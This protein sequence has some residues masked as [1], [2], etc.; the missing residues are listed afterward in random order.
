MRKAVYV[1]GSGADTLRF[2][3]EVQFG[4]EDSNGLAIMNDGFADFSPGRIQAHHLPWDIDQAS[5]ANAPLVGHSLPGHKVNAAVPT[6]TDVRVVST[7]AQSK[8]Y[9]AGENILVVVTFSKPVR[10]VGEPVLTLDIRHGGAPPQDYTVRSASYLGSNT[11]NTLTFKYVVQFGDN[12]DNGFIVSE[13]DNTGLGEGTIKPTDSFLWDWD[14][15]HGFDRNT[16]PHVQRSIP[17][18]RIATGRPSISDV[19]I[20]SSPADGAAYRLGETVEFD[21]TF[22]GLVAVEGAPKL[23]LRVNNPEVD[24]RDAKYLRKA[25]YTSGS[26]TNKL[27][28]S[29]AI[30]LGDSD[31]NGLA[32]RK[33]EGG[34]IH[35][36]QTYGVSAN[37]STIESHELFGRSLPGQEVDAALPTVTRVRV[38]S[39]PAQSQGYRVGDPIFVVV[40]FDKPVRVVGEPALTLDIRH[41]GAP[42]QDFTVRSA[43]YVGSNGPETL[44]FSYIVQTGDNDNNG[45]IVS[46]SD[47]TGLGEGTIKPAESSL[48]DLDALH[49]FD[50][51]TSPHVQR[52]IPGQRIATG[53]AVITD[54]E[55]ASS[56]ADGRAY[57]R[58]ES[59]EIDVTFNG[60]VKAVG[61][62]IL[63]LLVRSAD[64]AEDL[65]GRDYL[66]DAVYASGSGTETIRFSYAVRPYDQDDDGIVIRTNGLSSESG[67]LQSAHLPWDVDRD[68]LNRH[69]NVGSPRQ[70][71]AVAGRP[72]V[73][74]VDVTSSPAE[75]KVYRSGEAIEIEL[76]FDDRVRVEDTPSLIIRLDGVEQLAEY[77]SGNGSERLRFSY[78][79]Q[80]GDSDTNGFKIPDTGASQLHGGRILREADT[81]VE[82]NLSLAG[83]DNVGASL[84]DHRVKGSGGL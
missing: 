3:Y 7:P 57:R 66:R 81:S 46:E 72:Y 12:D 35:A 49:R 71:H 28:F 67:K 42:L 9:Q 61:K 51:G 75:G 16:S 68:S 43:P 77:R 64:A 21:L 50:R 4:D 84:P 47:D 83:L 74:A 53:R 25:V 23:R 38:T 2:V 52:S 29:Y 41:G 48:W 14:A 79:V 17:G 63:G 8:G 76:T 34:S 31:T 54:V 59:I 6:V 80:P 13:S 65:G 24:G 5:L 22:N 69:A 20:V 73:T 19:E 32:I 62:P 36:P 56:P 45:F 37:L 11:A 18:Q 27:R 70:G 10:V 60:K 58:G 44:T 55:I 39:T 30:Q 26:G 40:V 1:S 33:L 15:L 82:A 78:V